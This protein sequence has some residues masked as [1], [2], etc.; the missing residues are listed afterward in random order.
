MEFFLISMI[1]M[2]FATSLVISYGN[3]IKIPGET[4]ILLLLGVAGSVPLLFLTLNKSIET[5][6]TTEALAGTFFWPGL[7][8]I[9]KNKRGTDPAT[10]NNNKIPVSP[11]ILIELP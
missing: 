4:G 10:P 3:S 2:L 7:V 5:I 9:V 8:T 11:G 6:G 1:I